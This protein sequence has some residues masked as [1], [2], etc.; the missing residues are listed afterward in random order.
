MPLLTGAHGGRAHPLL[1]AR[2]VGAGRVVTDLLGHSLESFE[3]PVHRV[4]LQRAARWITPRGSEAS[5]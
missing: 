5:P 2:T 3:H 4:V 1:W